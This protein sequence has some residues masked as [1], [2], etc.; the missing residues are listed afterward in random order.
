[1]HYAQSVEPST[2]FQGVDTLYFEPGAHKRKERVTSILYHSNQE[3]KSSAIGCGVMRLGDYHIRLVSCSAVVMTRNPYELWVPGLGLLI[4]NAPY[5]VIHTRC[6]MCSCSYHV[7][8]AHAHIKFYCLGTVT[9]SS[10]M[11]LSPV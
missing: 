7:F 8:S 10:H 4:L 11:L 6:I 2:N 3:V 5:L 1:M 9:K